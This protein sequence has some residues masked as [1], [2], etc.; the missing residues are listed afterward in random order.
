MAS[1]SLNFRLPQQMLDDASEIAELLD[2]TPGWIARE[3]LKQ[4]L[5]AF[6]RG[7]ARSDRAGRLPKP[8]DD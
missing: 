5:A 8:S 2:R 6:K 3:A 4:Y 1:P 7:K